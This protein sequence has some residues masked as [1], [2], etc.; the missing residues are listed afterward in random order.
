M[1]DAANPIKAVLGAGLG[2][3]AAHNRRAVID[4]IRVNGPLSRAD[5]ARATRLAKQTLS[6][7]VEEL[8]TSGLLVACDPVTEGRGKPATPYDLAPMGA[9]SV[10]VQIDRT[11]ART[12]VMDLRGAVLSRRDAPLRSRDPEAGLKLVTRLLA[13][14]RAALAPDVRG[15]IVGLGIAMPGPFGPDA[16]ATRDDYTMAHWRGAGLAAQLHAATGLE[17]ALQ[18]DAAAAATAERLTG[19]AH[20]L[21][22]VV[23]LYLG[24][25]LGAGLILNGELYGGRHGDA[26]EIGMIPLPGSD[27]LLEHQVALAG[28]CETFAVPMADPRMFARIEAVLTR[29]G[30]ALD[31][32]IDRAAAGL[33][34]VAQMLALVTDPQAVILCGTAPRP[35]LERLTQA[36]NAAAPRVA[37]Q[38][39]HA[40]PWV[41]AMGAAAEPIARNFDPKYAALL[42]S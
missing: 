32:W 12:V 14:T 27:T 16:P 39:G 3:A 17:V 10:G 22:D 20:G 6:N 40:D 5:L 42:K 7:I 21:R 1:N 23:C 11:V 25:G 8:E 13:D 9:L 15:R 24:Y 2:A 31:A 18:N 35:L 37:L 33:G 34:W 36:V 41:V 4:A 26:G 28:F 38:L 29:G 30:P 19:R